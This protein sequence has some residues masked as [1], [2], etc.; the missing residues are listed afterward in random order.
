MIGPA[1]SRLQYEGR[2]DFGKAAG[3]LWTY[4]ATSVGVRFRGSRLEVLVTIYRA[5]WD[6]FLGYLLDRQE[7][8]VKLQESG[9]NRICLYDAE[10]G[11]AAAG[12]GTMAE[13]AVAGSD[14]ERRPTGIGSFCEEGKRKKMMG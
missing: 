1:D 14:D 11:S 10:K 3:P 9:I 5:F 8:C 13:D 4:P 7:Y 12:C 2:I 6:N